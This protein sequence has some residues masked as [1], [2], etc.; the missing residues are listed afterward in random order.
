MTAT[1][2]P[3]FAPLRLGAIELANR[4]VMAPLTRNRAE[5]EGRIPS[6]LAP[7]YYGQRA[8][9]G[10]IVAEATQISPMGQGYM[11]TPGIYSEAQ[12]AAWKQVTAEVH[13]R[14][15]RIVLQLWHVGRISHV[16]LLPDGA[17]PV[18]PS[19]LR[20]NA[21]TYTAEG[22]S[23]VSAPRALRLDE[24]PALLEDFRHA[25]RNA[26]AAG[27]DG[28]EVHA[29]NGYLI[30]QFLRDGSNHRDDAYGGSIENRTRLLFEVV[31]AVAQEI[32]A[33]RT[34]V[35][36]SPVTP[37]NDAHDSDPQPLFERAVERLDPLG[38]AFLHVI[39]G[40]T[41]GPRDNIAF[42]YAALRAKFRGPWLVNNGYD[43]ALAERVL[44]AGAADA[45]AFGRPFIA[46]PDLVERLRRDAPLNPLDADTLYGGGAKGYTDYPT[47]D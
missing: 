29:A 13:R 28:V 41:G 36:L 4:I 22:F 44:G 6:P 20:A 24:I 46:N 14:G 10:L 47:L 17:A 2:S 1:A 37:A 23:D 26:I 35:R 12:V 9:A 38:L 25:A 45:V 18:A 40:A 8:S 21:K 15:G 39:E 34:G 43:K 33:E 42:D 30:D 5:G 32:G 11:D 27:F 16:S 19:A 31:Q 3:L 7:E